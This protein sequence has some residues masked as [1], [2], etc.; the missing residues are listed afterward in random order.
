MCK[1]ILRFLSQPRRPRIG[2]PGISEIPE[3]LQKLY[4]TTLNSYKINFF[5]LLLIIRLIV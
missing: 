2:V 1:M 4:N 3:N 5:I